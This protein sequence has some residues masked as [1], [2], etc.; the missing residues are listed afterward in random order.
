MQSN[1]LTPHKMDT[2]NGETRQRLSLPSVPPGRGDEGG[3]SRR[4]GRMPRRGGWL[5]KRMLCCNGRDKLT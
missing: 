2:R 1:V 4:P 5:K 3:V